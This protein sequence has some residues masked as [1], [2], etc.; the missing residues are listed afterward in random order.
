MKIT[1]KQYAQTLFEMT[2]GKQKAEIEKSVAD[3]ARHM[4]K[5]RKLKLSEKIIESFEKIYNQK[6][7]IVEAEVVTAEKLSVAVEKKVKD[8]M[9]KK[10]SAKEVVVKNIVDPNI[11]GGMIV[12][13]GDEVM[14]GSV[15]GKL[16]EL[17][18]VLIK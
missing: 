3:F 6:N 14:D 15:A 5:E 16:S 4:Y 10:Y 2:D 17:K 18:K 8:Y 9:E 13:V 1:S 11:K 7:G 12:K